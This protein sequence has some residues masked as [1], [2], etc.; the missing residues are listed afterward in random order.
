[1]KKQH[2]RVWR[3]RQGVWEPHENTWAIDPDAPE[4]SLEVAK[5]F[6]NRMRHSSGQP[7]KLTIVTVTEE[8]VE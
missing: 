5:G 2:Y 6:A 4:L 7:Q 8:D 1:M 3:C